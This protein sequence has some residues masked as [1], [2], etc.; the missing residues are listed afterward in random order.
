MSPTPRSKA[1]SFIQ[2]TAGRFI[3]AKSRPSN[4]PQESTDEKAKNSYNKFDSYA[5]FGCRLWNKPSSKGQSECAACRRAITAGCHL[6]HR[7]RH[8]FVSRSRSFTDNPEKPVGV[9][10]WR[11]NGRQDFGVKR[12]GRSSEMFD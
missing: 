2:G 8:K 5:F 9:W 12:R 11:D 7:L 6:K 4:R 1:L 10:R 3:N